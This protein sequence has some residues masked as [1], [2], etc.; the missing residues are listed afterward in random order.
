MMVKEIIMIVDGVVASDVA[1]IPEKGCAFQIMIPDLGNVID[2]FIPL[3]EVNGQKDFM[4]GQNVKAE[5]RCP[6]ISQ[7]KI[8]F[9]VL[10]CK[11]QDDKDKSIKKII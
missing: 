2:V 5:I 9:K 7:G 10:S 3:A 6:Y 1:N 8:R 4:I 11:L